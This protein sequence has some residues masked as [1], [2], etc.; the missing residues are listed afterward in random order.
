MRSGRMS[1]ETSPYIVRYGA[2][3]STVKTGK[4]V[5][6]DNGQMVEQE[7]VTLVGDPGPVRSQR[8]AP[9]TGTIYFIGPADGPVKIGFASRLAVRLKDLRLANALPLEVLASVEGPPRLEREYHRRFAS[10][11]LHGEWFERTP[12]IEAEIAS[13]IDQ[14]EAA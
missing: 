14:S 13:L 10:A 7:I 6:G 1:R 9:E 12:E 11:R 4:M 3:A 8:P 5:P 2:T